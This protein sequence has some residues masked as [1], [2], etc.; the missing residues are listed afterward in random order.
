[1]ERKKDIFDRLMELP[2][3][4]LFQPFYE[5]NR[6]VLLYILFGG[7]TFLVSIFSFALCDV[8]LHMN[9]LIANVV[10]WIVAVSFAFF[11]NRIWVFQAPTKTFAEFIS[12]MAAFFGG[13]VITLVIEEV[14][15]LV[16]V[17]WL[18][19]NSMAVKV[20]AQIIVIVLNYVISKLLIFKKR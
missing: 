5:K 15:L 1:M 20:A 19:L 18:A 17:T 16:F 13:R 10:S 11:T 4:R 3:L 7:L 6:E 2:G 9:E 12:Q 8:A 14:I